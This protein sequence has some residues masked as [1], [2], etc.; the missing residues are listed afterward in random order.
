MG[1][2]YWCPADHVLRMHYLAG[3]MPQKMQVPLRY[4]EHSLLHHPRAPRATP[5]E[6]FDV[7]LR[8]AA[9]HAATC[10]HC[11]D[12]GYIGAAAWPPRPR[13]PAAR[14]VAVAG[15]A[16]GEEALHA[17]LGAQQANDAPLLHFTSMR[18]SELQLG[19]PPAKQRAFDESI[20][21]LGGGWC[22]VDPPTRGA[23]MHYW[24]DALF[25]QPHTDRW[26]RK[27][28]VDHPWTPFPGP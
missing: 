2:P 15:G 22:C 26:G 23:P 14:T 13:P 11:G 21:P 10:A 8:S 1:L 4:A 9:A 5:R 7:S 12:G 28:T 17:A 16:M 25:D 6:R 24:Y 27:W 18:P 20:K 3:V 19:F